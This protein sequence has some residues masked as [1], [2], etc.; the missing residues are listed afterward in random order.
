MLR[1]KVNNTFIFLIDI[2]SI[3]IDD[4]STTTITHQQGQ[5]YLQLYPHYLA[6]FNAIITRCFALIGY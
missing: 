5:A 2:L 6:S 4:I 3:F 1:R